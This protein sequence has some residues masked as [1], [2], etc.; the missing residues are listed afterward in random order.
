MK[1][2]L[3]FLIESI[4]VHPKD[5]SIEEKSLENFLNLTIK[6]NPDDLKIIIGKKGRTIKAIR[7][8]IKI[9]ALAD[10]K[11]VNVEVEAQVVKK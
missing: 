6:A 11:R 4:V 5:V 10:K 2:L 3:Q 9:R 1:K 8:L 7:E